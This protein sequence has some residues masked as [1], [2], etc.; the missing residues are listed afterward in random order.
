MTHQTFIAWTYWRDAC[1]WRI[2]FIISSMVQIQLCNIPA[3]N[4]LELKYCLRVPACS[5]YNHVVAHSSTHAHRVL[6]WR[7]L[8]VGTE[9]ISTCAAWEMLQVSQTGIDGQQGIIGSAGAS[10]CLN[11]NEACDR[12]ISPEPHQCCQVLP[13]QPGNPQIIGSHL[14]IH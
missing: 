9:K 2:L 8:P 4:Y 1:L 14:T 3:M 10:R 6:D 11:L 12:V 5:D 7:W 13:S